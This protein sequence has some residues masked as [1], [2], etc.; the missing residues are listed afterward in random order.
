MAQTKGVGTTPAEEME[1][2]FK[3][4][5]DRNRLYIIGLLKEQPRRV[6]E[7]AEALGLSEPTVSHHLSRLH[8]VGLVNLQAIGNTRVY[9]LRADVLEAV[10]RRGLDY[11][12]LAQVAPTPPPDTSWVDELPLSDEDRK[13]MKDHFEGYQL[14]VIPTKQ[15][16]LLVILRW[17]VQKFAPGVKYTE[18]EVNAVLK[19]IHPDYA[20]LRRELIDHHLLVRESGGGLYWRPPEPEAQ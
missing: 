2:F 19:A 18:Q 8:E 17:L 13:V 6:G 20:R 12:A 1:R 10:L 4:L 3:A 16:K 7:L 9:M 15:K 11:R 5:A 14:K